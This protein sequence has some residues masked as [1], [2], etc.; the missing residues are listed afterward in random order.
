MTT[1]TS[2]GKSPRAEAADTVA[3]KAVTI[4]SWVSE[5]SA[6]GATFEMPTLEGRHVRLEPL[7]MTHAADLYHAG[8]HPEIWQHLPPRKG[9]FESVDEVREWIAK[10]F[11]ELEIGERMPFAV[12]MQNDGQQDNGRPGAGQAIG[13]TSFYTENRWSNRTLEIGWTWFNPAH[14]GGPANVESKY[15]LLCFAFEVMGAMRVE[16]MAD[17]RNERS[18]AAIERLGATRDGLMRANMVLPDGSRRD[19]VLFGFIDE[20]WPAIKRGLE[21]RMARR[22]LAI[23][24]AAG[25]PGAI[26]AA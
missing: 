21:A 14:W 13:S 5:T 18:Q 26:R 6:G 16:L 23:R 2:A 4:K 15:L 8:N 10:T 25:L 24:P 1:S 3:V 11:A 19:S 9:P 17:A 20:D 22:R 12:V 7:A